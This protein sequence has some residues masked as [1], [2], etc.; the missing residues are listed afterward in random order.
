M[1]ELY[2]FP[3]GIGFPNPSPFCAK[4]ETWLRLAGLEYAL[5]EKQDPRKA[6]LG[7][8]P[9]IRHQ[10]REVPDSSCAI[11]YLREH[12]DVTLDRSLS[13]EQ[14]RLSHLY[15]RMLEEH[16]YFAL[17]YARWL[18]DD[19]WPQT[20]EGYF[21]Y[22]PPLLRSFLPDLVRRSVRRDAR[23]QGL[24]RHPGAEIYR[25]LGQDLAAV[26]GELGDKDY[27][28]GTEPSSVDAVIYAFVGS[29][30]ESTIGGPAQDLARSHDNLVA[31][32][33]R[34]RARCFS[35]L[36]PGA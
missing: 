12:F 21:G 2:Q 8:L 11:D 20:R 19:V 36:A 1:I 32:C 23:G 5:I 29:L 31:Y 13:P 34:M 6:P 7:K 15:Q 17:I 4:L 25:R 33:A 10:G 9:M 35:D 16:S 14:Q 18:D 27:F 22:L 3:R 30:A 26:A 28:F 24:S